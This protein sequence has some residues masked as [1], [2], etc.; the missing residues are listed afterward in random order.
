MASVNLD[1]K[2]IEELEEKIANSKD[3]Y[4][5]LFKRFDPKD[6]RLIWSGASALL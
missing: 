6:V 4:A 5:Q 3:I 2:R 1:D